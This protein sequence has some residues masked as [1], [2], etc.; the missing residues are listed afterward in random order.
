ME[1]DPTQLYVG[2][3]Q[4]IIHVDDQGNT[5]AGGAKP[6]TTLSTLRSTPTRPTTIPINI[7]PGNE[8]IIEDEQ[9]VFSTENGNRLWIQDDSGRTDIRVTLEITERGLPSTDAS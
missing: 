3:D 4:L 8:T 7:K 6:T 1:Y 9:L 5:G 2:T